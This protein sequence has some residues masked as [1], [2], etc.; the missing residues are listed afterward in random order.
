MRIVKIATGTAALVSLMLVP[1]VA[2]QRGNSGNHGPTTHATPPSHAGP[3]AS[4]GPKTTKGPAGPSAHAT[5]PKSHEPTSHGPSAKG[6]DARS[7]KNAGT[8]TNTS[9]TTTK[10][11]TT[12]TLTTVDFAATPVGEKLTKNTALQSKL[13]TKL[14]ALG[15]K[16]TVF[17]AAYGFKNLG[18]LVAATNV[19]QNLNIPFE[20]LKLQMTGLTVD[21]AGNVVKTDSP[22]MSL[23]QAIQTLKPGVDATTTT[24]TATVEAE[25]EIENTSHTST[26]T[27]TARPKA[28]RKKS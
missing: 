2:G 3:P 5:G 27:T 11:T 12:T 1:L 4:A 25:D 24:K 19:S 14:A 16:G 6:T 10:A 23:G 26:T 7:P 15:Y 9:T 20:Q 17:E 21:A 28:T 8:T 18:Q 22:T 13:T